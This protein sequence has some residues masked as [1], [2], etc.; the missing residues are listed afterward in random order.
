[1]P[2][3]GWTIIGVILFVAELVA[4]DAHFYLIFLGASALAVGAAA[5]LGVDMPIWGEWLLFAVLS[6]TFMLTLREQ[7]YQR[8]RGRAIGTDRLIGTHVSL[9]AE[10][11]P[12]ATCRTDYQGTSWTALN[13]GSGVIPAGGRARIDRVDGITL[14]ISAAAD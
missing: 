9:A 6:I 13:V 7:L 14:H 5:Y 12:G 3:W 4:I 11:A 8:M 10:L 2:W 1:M